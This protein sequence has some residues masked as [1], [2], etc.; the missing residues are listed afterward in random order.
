MI[1]SARLAMRLRYAPYR[2]R[3]IGDRADQRVQGRRKG[4]RGASPST[5]TLLTRALKCSLFP[6]RPEPYVPESL[7]AV[8]N[9]VK[10]DAQHLE[11]QRAAQTGE[12]L[13]MTC[14][15]NE[16]WTTG[17]LLTDR[18]RELLLPLPAPSS[19]L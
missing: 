2:P 5:D 10:A 19:R 9:V 16:V 1:R 7:K 12:A 13:Q 14:T 18:G 11:G 4:S 3:S 8:S 6:C 15:H 17:P